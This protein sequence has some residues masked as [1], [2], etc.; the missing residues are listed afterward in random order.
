M[1]NAEPLA[2]LADNYIWMARDHAGAAAI[3]VDPGDAEVVATWLNDHRLRLSGILVTHHH[4]DH[5]AGVAELAER[6]QV[7]VFGPAGEAIPAVNHLVSGGDHF[8]L[9]GFGDFR[10]LDCPGHTAGHIAYLWDGHLFSGDTLFAGGCGR[11][12]EGTAGQMHASLQRLAGLP[13]DTRVCCG[14]E[15]TVKNLEFA[16]RADPDNE[17]L[18]QRLQA[19]RHARAAGQPTVPSTLAEELATNP[20]L[21]ADRPELRRSAQDWCGKDL[22]QADHVFAALRQWKDAS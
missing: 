22:E 16:H 8:A 9:D 14:H 20:F 17:R 18:A 7:P 19:A 12:F 1:I 21:R 11:V 15:Y 3:A 4:G 6:H 5:T 2:A 10:V 13:A